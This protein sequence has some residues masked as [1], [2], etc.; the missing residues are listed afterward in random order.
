[1]NEKQSSE[2]LR[3]ILEMPTAVLFAEQLKT[4]LEVEKAKRRRF[5][6]T[7]DEESKMEFING[8]TLFQSPSKLR[9]IKAIG[10]LLTLLRTF[11]DKYE[12]GF[13]AS[14]K[15]LISLSRNDYEPDICFFNTDKAK[16]FTPTQMQFPAPDLVVEVLSESTEKK[17]RTTKFAD[18][19]AHGISEYWIVDPNDEFIE[20]YFLQ[21]EVYQLHL[22][23]RDGIV[24]SFVLPNFQIPI[25]AAFDE[26]VNLGELGKIFSA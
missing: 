13:V 10:L 23:A 5:Y 24:Q 1:M 18:Y 22:K 19:A 6:E 2:V 25:R 14:E 12:L 9:H 17:D 20:Q 16:N 8:E 15:A 21:N 26:K 11:V 7:M 3:Q 4:V